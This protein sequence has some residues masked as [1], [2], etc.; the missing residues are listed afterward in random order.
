M[1]LL[2]PT[3]ESISAC[4]FIDTCPS[5]H[6]NCSYPHAHLLNYHHMIIQHVLNLHII[7]MRIDI[8][9][10]HRSFHTHTTSSRFACIVKLVWT[11]TV[12][13]NF[14]QT[15]AALACLCMSPVPM[16][17]DRDLFLG[18]V[19]HVWFMWSSDWQSVHQFSPVTFCPKEHNE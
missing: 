18:L 1:S 12:L 9:H 4:A 15:S 13:L 5:K 16:A 11:P 2:L 6:Y 10:H 17:A 3:S 8:A 7:H 14:K 19:G